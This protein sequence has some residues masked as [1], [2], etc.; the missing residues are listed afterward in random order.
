MIDVKVDD[1]EVTSHLERLARKVRDLSPIMREISE[2]ML[3]A[4]Q[5]NFDK[6]GRPGRWPELSPSYKRWLT[7]KGKTGK[8]LNRSAAGLY[9]S[10]TSR[11][12]ADS[13]MVGTNKKYAAIHHFGGTVRINPATRTFV[14]NGARRLA[15]NMGHSVKIPARPY[16][17]LDDSDTRLIVERMKRYLDE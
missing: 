8:M 3:D 11:S 12:D 4:V 9:H 10:I 13:A 14:R 1:R 5:E 15:I 2:D 6:E 16:L 17:H 7:R